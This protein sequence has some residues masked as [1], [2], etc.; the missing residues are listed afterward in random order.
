[1]A[2]T[3]AP[4]PSRIDKFL[5][6]YDFAASYGIRINAPA[7]VVYA[8]L[9]KLDLNQLWV[10]RLLMTLR[11]GRRMENRPVPGD[12]PQRLRGTGFVLLEETLGEEMVIGVAGKFWRPDGG[13]VMEL[14]ANDFSEFSRPGYAKA[15][16]NFRLQA[17]SPKSTALSTETRIKC[18]GPGALLRFRIYWALIRPFSGSMRQAMLNKIRTEAESLAREAS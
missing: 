17:D 12:L 4:G 16:W 3:S 8:Q 14:T 15:A 2:Y 7:S 6:D 13:R 5:P 9:L 10:V 11:L 1:M 18:F